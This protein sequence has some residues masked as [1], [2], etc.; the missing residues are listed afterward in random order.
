MPWA[1]HPFCEPIPTEV[2]RIAEVLDPVVTPFGFA[3]GQAG[4]AD[5]SGQVIFCRG[6]WDSTD[7]GCVDLVIDVGRDSDW[8]ITGVRYWGSPSKEWQLDVEPDGELANQLDE[9]ARTLASKLP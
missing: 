6:I 4:V 2:E 8:R 5:G 7:G 3:P 9:L 1:P